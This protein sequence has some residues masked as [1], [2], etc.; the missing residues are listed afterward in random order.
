MSIDEMDYAFQRLGSGD[1]ECCMQCR[2]CASHSTHGAQC[3]AALVM[4]VCAM[5]C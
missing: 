5:V 4:A 1:M 2:A 3:V